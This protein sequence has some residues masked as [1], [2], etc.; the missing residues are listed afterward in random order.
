MTRALDSNGDWVFGT[1]ISA[2][3]TGNLEI[4]QNI[5]TRLSSFLNDC[6]FDTTAGVNWLYLLGS[7]NQAA[8]NLAVGAVI[9]NTPNVTGGLELSVTYNAQTRNVSIVYN[10]TTVYSKLTNGFSYD[11]SVV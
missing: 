6:F 3:L 1:G 9:L 2:Y 7:K 4:A 8:L 10:V 5:K 11:L